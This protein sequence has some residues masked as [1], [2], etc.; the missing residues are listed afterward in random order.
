MWKYVK[1]TSCL[2]LILACFIPWMIPIPDVTI[3]TQAFFSDSTTK[4]SYALIA[5]ALGASCINLIVEYFT[6]IR[7][8]QNNTQVLFT[9]RV[10]IAVAE[11]LPI[12]AFHA[13]YFHHVFVVSERSFQR[14]TTWNSIRS[15]ITLSPS[16]SHTHV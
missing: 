9:E 1:D 3:D 6:L 2:L 15:L 8:S 5:T 10:I 12:V 11:L 16:L 4:N 7:S 14:Q 13:Y